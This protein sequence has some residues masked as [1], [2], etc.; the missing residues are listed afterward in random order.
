M[1]DIC[2][3]AL[4]FVRVGEYKLS[5]A[6]LIVLKFAS[7]LVDHVILIKSD[8]PAPDDRIHLRDP[9]AVLVNAII[10][11]KPSNDCAGLE[12]VL[13]YFFRDQ[14]VCL[15]P[16]NSE[17]REIWLLACEG[18]DWSRSVDGEVAVCQEIT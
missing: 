16:Y 14:D 9:H 18:L 7:L 17:V 1:I 3:Q 2:S 13:S 6:F 5:Q 15:R 12:F 11:N 10:A 8:I 4:D